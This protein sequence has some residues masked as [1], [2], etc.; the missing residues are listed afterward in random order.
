MEE[1]YAIEEAKKKSGKVLSIGFQ[2][3]LDANMQMIKKI[4]QSGELGKVYYIQKQVF[5]E[6]LFFAY[7]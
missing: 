3:R 2:P 7:G 4:V 5:V 6:H 1:A